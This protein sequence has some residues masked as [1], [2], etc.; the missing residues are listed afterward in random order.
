LSNV[1]SSSDGDGGS[2]SWEAKW[3]E[4]E[5]NMKEAMRLKDERHTA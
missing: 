3:K 2:S 4:V 1:K 5:Q